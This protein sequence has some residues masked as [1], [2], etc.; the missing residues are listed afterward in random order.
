MRGAIFHGARHFG[1]SALLRDMIGVVEERELRTASGRDSGIDLRKFSAKSAIQF[2]GRTQQ[3]D[4]YI[5]GIRTRSTPQTDLAQVSSVFPASAC[6]I[7]GR[8]APQRARFSAH[9]TRYT[10]FG[11]WLHSGLSGSYLGVLIRDRK[12]S[13]CCGSAFGTPP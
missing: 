5:W 4:A 12:R 10:P 13:F 8:M 3:G 9:S 2:V 6:R 1:A 11:R 7:S